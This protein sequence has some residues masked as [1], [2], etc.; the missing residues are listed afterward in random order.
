MIELI[1][2][3]ANVIEIKKKRL[4]FLPKV[5]RKTKKSNIIY[6]NQ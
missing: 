4:M 5:I 6:S 2:T 1:E 3:K